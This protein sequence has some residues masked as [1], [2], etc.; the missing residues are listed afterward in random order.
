[1]TQLKYKSIIHL[2]QEVAKKTANLQQRTQLKKRQPDAVG[3]E[4]WKEDDLNGGLATLITA[5]VKRRTRDRTRERTRPSQ[6]GLD[7]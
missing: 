6:Y 1:M 7:R 3:A 2:K 5:I 4:V